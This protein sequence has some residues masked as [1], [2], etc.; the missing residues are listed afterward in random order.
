MTIPLGIRADLDFETPASSLTVSQRVIRIKS[1]EARIVEGNTY[2]TPLYGFQGECLILLKQIPEFGQHGAWEANLEE[3]GLSRRHATDSMSIAREL[4]REEWYMFPVTAAA[5]LARQRK[6]EKQGNGDPVGH[7]QQEPGAPLTRWE[8][9]AAQRLVKTIGSIERALDVLTAVQ[10][11]AEPPKKD[12]STNKLTDVLPI[13]KP[14]RRPE[15]KQNPLEYLRLLAAEIAVNDETYATRRDDALA[16][17]KAEAERR[18]LTQ[19][20]IATWNTMQCG[21]SKAHSKET[22]DIGKAWLCR[23]WQSDYEKN[24]VKFVA[25]L[26]KQVSG[27]LNTPAAAD[28]QVADDHK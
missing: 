3:W 25:K 11:G 18:A 26:T 23:K 10:G 13:I 8:Y 2:L 9:Q 14:K 4:T 6:R 12:K 19:D 17:A 27:L 28:A 16:G 20:D 15:F 22:E 1:C 21:L 5:E 24:P 7:E